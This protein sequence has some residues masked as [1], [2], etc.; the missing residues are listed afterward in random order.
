MWDTFRN[1]VNRYLGV[2]QSTR[3]GL[4]SVLMLWFSFNISYK[5]LCLKTLETSAN[6]SN[7]YHVIYGWIFSFI[8]SIWITFENK[9][10]TVT[11]ILSNLQSCVLYQQHFT[12]QL[13]RWIGH[14][15]GASLN[16]K[17]EPRFIAS[18]VWD[19]AIKL[20]HGRL[21]HDQSSGSVAW[22]S[23]VGDFQ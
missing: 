20:I 11:H 22:W 14:V 12:R 13:T 23:I 16:K 21:S 8:Q 18:H 5:S 3:G 2:N 7:I 19:R 15:T 4:I 9:S 6:N 17:R 1:E 10:V